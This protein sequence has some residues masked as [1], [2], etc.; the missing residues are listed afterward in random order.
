MKREERLA[1]GRRNRAAYVERE[2]KKP[3]LLPAA[4]LTF[5]WKPLPTPPRASSSSSSAAACVSSPACASVAALPAAANFAT[6][7]ACVSSPACTSSAVFAFSATCASSAAAPS[8]VADFASAAVPVLAVVPV[9]EDDNKVMDR[10]EEQEVEAMEM[11]DEARPA[12][13]HAFALAAS[14]DRASAARALITLA[15]AALPT[16]ALASASASGDSASE[17]VDD[18]DDVEDDVEDEVGYQSDE[19]SDTRTEGKLHEDG[20]V[21]IPGKLDLPDTVIRVIKAVNYNQRGLPA[22]PDPLLGYDSRRMQSTDA[23]GNVS[24]IKSLTQM[25]STHLSRYNL[26]TTTSGESKRLVRVHALKSTVNV[27]YNESETEHQDGD[28]DRHVDEPPLFMARFMAGRAVADMPLSVLVALDAGA[29]LRVWPRGGGPP[30]L[31]RLDL[32]EVLVFRGDLC[33]AGLGY[34]VENVRVHMYLYHP[35]YRPGPSQIH[36]CQPV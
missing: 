18:R 23:R 6:S 36:A 1:A 35:A 30:M 4:P 15:A 16:L 11:E 20:F 22:A 33:H 3:N 25:V 21:I 2:R 9:G 12:P 19:G 17:G 10:V 13:A 7:A 24:W 31:I 29:K 34:R 32:G 5:T 27:G 28:Q 26:M 14:A 8:P